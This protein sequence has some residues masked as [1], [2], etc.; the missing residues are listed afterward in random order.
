MLCNHVARVLACELI[1]CKLDSTDSCSFGLQPFLPRQTN[2]LQAGTLDTLI[3]GLPGFPD[4]INRGSD[5]SF[6]LALV[7]PDIPL[8]RGWAARV[9]ACQGRSGVDRSLLSG[10]AW[11]PDH[12]RPCGCAADAPHPAQAL[13]ARPGGPPAG[14]ADPQ[15]AVGL[16]GQGEQCRARRVGMLQLCSTA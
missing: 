9:H 14:L 4:N 5:G 13:A 11:P 3:E 1:A 7:I 6:W 2:T 16:R 12:R 10:M 8:V 15:E